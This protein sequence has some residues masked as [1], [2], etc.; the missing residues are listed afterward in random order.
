VWALLAVGVV[1]LLA[2][3]RRVI[4]RRRWQ[5]PPLSRAELVR[6]GWLDDLRR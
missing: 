6:R 2:S 3:L 4:E 1:V 5:D